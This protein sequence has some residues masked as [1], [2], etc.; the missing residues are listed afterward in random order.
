MKHVLDKLYLHQSA[1]LWTSLTSL[2]MLCA[3]VLLQAFNH[4]R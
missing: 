3:Y 2:V 4:L 1:V